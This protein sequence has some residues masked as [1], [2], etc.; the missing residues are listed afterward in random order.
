MSESNGSSIEIRKDVSKSTFQVV[1][2]ERT[3]LLSTSGHH[4]G[5]SWQLAILFIMGEVLGGGV[6]AIGSA[7]VGTGNK[8][9]IYF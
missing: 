2:D 3:H 4:Y 8:K 7:M 1:D 9:Y 6:V 5:L